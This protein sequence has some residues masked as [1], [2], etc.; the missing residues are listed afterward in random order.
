MTV[1]MPYGTV[2]LTSKDDA[3]DFIRNHCQ[4]C[5]NN[6]QMSPCSGT[7]AA[8]CNEQI[9]LVIEHFTKCNIRGAE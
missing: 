9:N 3:A 2:I 6:N 4:N 7:M 5:C 1:N 8:K